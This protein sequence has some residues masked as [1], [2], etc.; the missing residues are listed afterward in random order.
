MHTQFQLRDDGDLAARSLH[1]LIINPR[2]AEV[3][4]LTHPALKAF[5][6]TAATELHRIRDRY[7]ITR[8]DLILRVEARKMRSKRL[9]DDVFLERNV[10]AAHSHPVDV[11]LE[12][13][14]AL[15]DDE[16][17]HAD[18]IARASFKVERT[19]LKAA[20]D[21][22]L[23]LLHCAMARL[24]KDAVKLEAQLLATEGH[25]IQ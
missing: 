5:Y 3:A 8:A 7:P 15:S 20:S 16:N 6:R 1:R 4:D 14:H 23:A 2:R 12:V 17:R 10:A 25:R 21:T 19:S 13:E 24:A 18:L 9:E 22:G 11:A